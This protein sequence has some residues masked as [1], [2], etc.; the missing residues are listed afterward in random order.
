MRQKWAVKYRK[1]A[2][3]VDMH[4]VHDFAVDLLQCHWLSAILAAPPGYDGPKQAAAP[5]KSRRP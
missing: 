3:A 5:G 1:E 2:N 4:A